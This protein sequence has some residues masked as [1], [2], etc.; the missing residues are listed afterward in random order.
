VIGGREGKKKELGGGGASSESGEEKLLVGGLALGIVN[1][2]ELS[3]GKVVSGGNSTGGWVAISGKRFCSSGVSSTTSTGRLISGSVAWIAVSGS[4]GST[5]NSRPCT[6]RE[7][8]AAKVPGSR[9]IPC[10]GEPNSEES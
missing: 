7:A 1:S 5:T 8:R 10:W 2:G 3:L 9:H 4:S 6:P